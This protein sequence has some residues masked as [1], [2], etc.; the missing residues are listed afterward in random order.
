MPL[1]QLRMNEEDNKKCFFVRPHGCLHYEH[2]PWACRMFPLDER[3]AGGFTLATE[4][5]RC[6]GLV[7]GDSWLV[8]E[9]LMDQGAT[10]AKESDGSFE[11]LVAHEFMQKMGSVDNP[12][13]Q[14]MLVMSLYDIDRFRDFVFGSSFLERFELEEDQIDAIKTGDRALL[15][16]AFDWVRFGLLGQ[17]SLNLKEEAKKRAEE[18]NDAASAR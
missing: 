2:R 3:G 11:S 6:H 15:D 5:S 9:W 13:I 16:L 1:V 7:K 8:R 18:K 17:K 14:Q 12:Q 4:G 10:Q